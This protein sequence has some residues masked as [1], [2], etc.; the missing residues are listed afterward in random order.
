MLY[1]VMIALSLFLSSLVS[2]CR[3]SKALYFLPDVYQW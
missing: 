2:K 3:L 1:I